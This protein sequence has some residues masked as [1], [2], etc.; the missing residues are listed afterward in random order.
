LVSESKDQSWKLVSL[1][2]GEITRE[3]PISADNAIMA[4]DPRYV[5]LTRY[6]T[7]SVSI[8]DLEANVTVPTPPNLGADVYNGEL[9]MLNPDG[10]LLFSHL[11]QSDALTGGR[12]PLGPLHALRSALADSSL[13][14]LTIS[15]AGGGAVFDL[16]TGRRL[17]VDSGFHGVTFENAG[18]AFLVTERLEKSAHMVRS[19][20]H[21]MPNQPPA[22]N[23]FDWSAEQAF[24]LVSSQRSLISYSFYSFAG[25]SGAMIGLGGEIPFELRGLD[26]ASGH[27]L[28]RHRYE[29]DPPLPF[30]DPQ[31]SRI[32]L[33]WKANADAARR[34]A[35]DFPAAREA[36]K[37][38]KVKDLDTFFEVMD[39]A[40][41]T[42][43]GGVLIQYGS[44]PSGFD[45]A[46]S[47]GNLL[48]IA[49]DAYRLSLYQ[50][51]DGKL[52]GRLR[53][54]HPAVSEPAKIFALADENGKLAIY[55]SEN[56]AKLALRPFPEPIAYLRFS[57]KGD[58]LLALTVHQQAVIL[59]VKKTLEEFPAPPSPASE[60]P[61]KDQ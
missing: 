18:S 25:R 60:A 61:A 13:S 17:S 9:A 36:Y 23:A 33:G 3:L 50:L 24:E 37:K 58:R 5:L 54:Q 1:S 44:G 26:P 20:S 31:G 12:L 41:C 22:A 8:F 47:A 34:A 14:T 16:A 43:L 30:A 38:Q 49:K 6:G 57:E 56:A 27:E 21:W 2:T 59:D 55:S 40:T 52:I 29:N 4:S 45:S 32:V 48:F 19:V 10:R 11:R 7:S 15:V 46:F 39:A 28:W 51:S 35:K 53:G 42:S